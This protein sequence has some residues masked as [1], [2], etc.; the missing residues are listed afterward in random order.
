ML[1]PSQATLIRTVVGGLIL[2]GI[3]ATFLAYRGD[4]GAASA[5]GSDVSA[6]MSPMAALTAARPAARSAHYQLPRDPANT[7]GAASEREFYVGHVIAKPWRAPAGASA[8]TQSAAGAIAAATTIG[9]VRSAGLGSIFVELNDTYRAGFD[10]A[11]LDSVAVDTKLSCDAPIDTARLAASAEYASA[12]AIATLRQSGQF[13]Y[14]ERD[15]VVDLAQQSA[16]PPV[17]DPLFSLQWPL[18][19]QGVRDGASPGGAGFTEFWTRAGQPGSQSVRVAVIDTGIDFTHPQIAAS[20]NIQPGIDAISS[21]ARAGDGDRRD[22]DPSDFGELCYDD[23][24]MPAYHGTQI[25]GLI[26]GAMSNDATGPAGAAWRV[27][28]VPIRAVGACGGL[29]SD[30]AEAIIWASGAQWMVVDR[31]L[32]GDSAVQWIDEPAQIIN[33]SISFPAPDGCPRLLQDAIDIATDQGSVIVAPAGNDGGNAQDFAPGNCNNVVTVAASDAAGR[34]AL[35][36]NA[37]EGV[38]ILAPGGDLGADENADGR[39]DGV[40]VLANAEDCVDMFTDEPVDRCEAM[41]VSGTSYAAAYVSA[42]LALL[43]AEYPQANGEDLVSLLVNV[44]RTPRTPEHC[45]RGCGA[46]LLNLGRAIDAG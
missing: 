41:M 45:P 36:S 35:Y 33:L 8:N 17:N 38:D 27:G 24:G 13:E 15:F 26:G 12:C 14:V 37:G 25:A 40:L 18:L 34:L 1:N 23:F 9:R 5:A 28:V 16:G 7:A 4:L 46:G 31:S 42:A 32:S 19:A 2:S 11:A 22:P 3:M 43:S 39:P 20:S 44:A 30:V 29:I 6:R 21:P 10:P